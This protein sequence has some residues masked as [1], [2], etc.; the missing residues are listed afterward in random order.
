MDVPSG[1]FVEVERVSDGMGQNSMTI[2]D[3]TVTMAT[4]NQDILKGTVYRA[5][6]RG[7]NSAGDGVFSNYVIGETD[8]DRKL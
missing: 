4:F 1:W 5:R 8:V 6:V 2:N 3:P 7:F